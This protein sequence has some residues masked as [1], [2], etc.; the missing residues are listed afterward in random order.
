M[1]RNGQGW[2]RRTVPPSPSGSPPSRQHHSDPRAGCCG[3]ERNQALGRDAYI[4]ACGEM[5]RAEEGVP[6]RGPV[7]GTGQS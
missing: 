5:E 2:G 6:Q 1:R 7:L 3:H 4:R